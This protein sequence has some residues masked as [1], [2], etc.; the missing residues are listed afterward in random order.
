M[1][2]DKG[3]PS[4]LQTK[5]Y[6]T[7]G[8]YSSP[9]WTEITRTKGEKLPRGKKE[10]TWECRDSAYEKAKGGHTQLA[11]TFQ[12]RHVRGAADSVRTALL[13]SLVNGSAIELLS[14]DAPYDDAN[15]TGFRAHYEVMKMDKTAETSEVVTYEVEAKHTE[16]YDSGTLIEPTAYTYSAPAPTTTAAPTTTVP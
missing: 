3:T 12:Y 8:S 9:T 1:P 10:I 6:Y 11:L 2:V 7:S 16:Y 15:V 4:G 13:A 5:L 14:C